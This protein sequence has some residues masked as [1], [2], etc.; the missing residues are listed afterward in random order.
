MDLLKWLEEW[1]LSMCDGYWEHLYG[2]KIDTLDN[3][4]WMVLI[5]IVET[6]LEQKKFETVSKYSADDNWIHCRV[7]DGQFDGGGDPSKLIEI[8]KVFK[9]WVES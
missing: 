4:G 6:P 9:E 8:L 5:D 7:K 2:V 1:Y 3:P